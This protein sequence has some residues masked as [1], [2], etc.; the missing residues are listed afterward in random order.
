MK[1]L[2]SIIT[3]TSIAFIFSPILSTKAI[4][5]DSLEYKQAKTS[6]KTNLKACENSKG[7]K[8]NGNC[9]LFSAISDENS[10][11]YKLVDGNWQ[12]TKLQMFDSSVFGRI[13]AIEV[14]RF[15]KEWAYG[16]TN[17]KTPGEKLFRIR[18]S[19]IHYNYGC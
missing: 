17:N 6:A 11:V 19:T 4:L 7:S 2:I 9:V 14:V 1:K 15:D 10:E 13:S 16:F 3:F 12:S 5:P 8:I 18:M